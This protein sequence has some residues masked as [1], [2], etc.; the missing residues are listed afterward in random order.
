MDSKQRAELRETLAKR[1]RRVR[2]GN[3]VGYGVHSHTLAEAVPALLA[4]L[5][6]LRAKV[7]HV[8]KFRHY[9][10][11]YYVYLG[12]ARV[13]SD[14]NGM[15]WA[16]YAGEDGSL[17]IRP[18]EEFFGTVEVDGEQVRRFQEVD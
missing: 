15:R 8:R 14:W 9:K 13:E 4:E 5:R 7:A 2:E 3:Q 6:E 17:I 16:V 10:G 1:E 18:A 12:N 11:N